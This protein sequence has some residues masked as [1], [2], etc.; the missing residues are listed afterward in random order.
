MFIDI[1]VHT[2]KYQTFFREGKQT[3]ITPEQLIKTYD[4]I[5]V[6]KGVILAGSGSPECRLQPQTIEEAFE[7]CQQYPGRFIP[8]CNID[9]REMTNS[10]DAPLEVI[11]SYYKK[12]GCKGIGEI[13]ANMPFLHPMVQNLFRHAE[14]VNLP[15]TFHIA[16]KIGGTYGLYDDQGLPQLEKSLQNFPDLFFLGH[17]QPFW[18]EIGILETPA[19]RCGYSKYPVKK[20]G[21]LPKLFRRYKNLLGDL[22]AFSGFNAIARDIDYGIKFLNEFQ[23]RLFF[24]TDI[25]TPD[26]PTPL[27]EFL[28]N[29]K[30]T[31]KISEAVFKKIAKENALKLLRFSLSGY[32]KGADDDLQ[33][34]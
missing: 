17:S 20:E 25:T 22:S 28:I 16:P 9:P 7:I 10:P 8:F 29:L 11:L 33:R 1:Y 18:A 13:T 14:K 4:R 21:A 2:R 24:G 6:E 30:D 15:V 12:M 34:C 32:L 5:G 19:D 31:G 26:T 27:V 23:D 3:Y